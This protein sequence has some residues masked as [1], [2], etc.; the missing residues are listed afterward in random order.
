MEDV[1]LRLSCSF[2]EEEEEFD[3]LI[4]E[5]VNILIQGY[6][7]RQISSISSIG[8]SKT[9]FWFERTVSRMG[10]EQFRSTFRL[11]KEMFGWLCCQSIEPVP[12][13]VPLPKQLAI[14]IYRLA[15]KIS[16]KEL[17]DK[18]DLSQGYIHSIC[19]TMSEEIVSKVKEK[20]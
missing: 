5:Q 15:H 12:G 3:Q 19:R 20:T 1:L 7:L 14:F 9:S 11:T 17:A 16:V 2:D 6:N 4:L 13:R 18:F 8:Q 10:D